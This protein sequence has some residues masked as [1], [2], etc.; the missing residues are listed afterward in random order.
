MSTTGQSLNTLFVFF[1]RNKPLL[2][3]KYFLNTFNYL[4]VKLKYICHLTL[5]PFVLC[6]SSPSVVRTL[7]VWNMVVRAVLQY[8]PGRKFGS[9]HGHCSPALL[10]LEDNP[11]HVWHLLR[12]LLIGVSAVCKERA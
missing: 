11:D 12:R 7:P 4:V 6:V 8:E 2:Y 10:R 1:F 3:L 5:L 9:H